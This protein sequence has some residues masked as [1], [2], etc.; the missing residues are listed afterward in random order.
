MYKFR[1]IIV[2]FFSF[3]SFSSYADFFSAINDEPTIYSSNSLQEFVAT[4]SQYEADTPEK[5]IFIQKT[6]DYYKKVHILN[7]IQKNGYIVDCIPFAEQPA[8]IDFPELAESLID[9]VKMN[10]SQNFAELAR[11]GSIFEVNSSLECPYGSVAIIRP[12]KM[13]LTSKYTN[14]KDFFSMNSDPDIL[15]NSSGS[16]YTWE[17]GVNANNQLIQIKTQKA[18]AFFRGPQLQSVTSSSYADHSI[19]Q[20]WLINRDSVGTYSVEFG[21]IASAYFTHSPS[22]SIFIFASVDNY[23]SKS[24]YN[25]YCSNFVQMPGTPAFGVPIKNK[26]TDFIFQV[27]H[28]NKSN[29]QS[30][31]YLTLVSGSSSAQMTT[32]SMGYYPDHVYPSTNVL[33]NAF[34]VGAEVYANSPNNG[35]VMY[36]NYVNPYPEY[37]GEKQISIFTQNG[38]YFPFYSSVEA[39]PYNLIWHFGQKK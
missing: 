39:F 15:F 24:C 27:N 7:S 38:N 28:I 21:L 36:G 31:Y 34:S 6:I 20:F 30:G 23:G 12:T 13:L 11:I 33:P 14:K 10:F 35:T 26:N 16:G 2:S 3:F 19:A 4:I 9:D 1:I 29:A 8:L 17:Q 25:M 5:S 37:Q 18:E 32:L 22:T